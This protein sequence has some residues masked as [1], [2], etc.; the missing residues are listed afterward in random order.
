MKNIALL[1]T[2]IFGLLFLGG[3]GSWAGESVF[4]Y[5]TNSGENT[6]SA[7]DLVFGGDT[8]LSIIARPSAISGNVWGEYWV[9]LPDSNLLV[10]YGAM[11]WERKAIIKKRIRTNKRPEQILC[12]GRYYVTHP[13]NNSIS[14]I[15]TG[16][17]KIIKEIAVGLAP[18]GLALSNDGSL[19]A[20]VNM[21]SDDVTLIR[22]SDLHTIGTYKVGKTPKRAAFSVNDSLLFVSLYGENAVAVLDCRTGGVVK[23]I[24]VGRNPVGVLVTPGGHVLYVANQGTEVKPDNRVTKIKLPSFKLTTQLVCG[25]GCHGLAYD[26]YVESVVVTNFFDNTL[27]IISVQGEIE[28]RKV[29]KRPT[30]VTF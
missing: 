18:E 16:A 26:R 19:L 9:V 12:S 20:V 1:L 25:R 14:V 29:G 22:T 3:P 10:A 11:G 28:T 24:P 8:T 2:V 15:D 27:S 30:C 6:I 13:E 5:C 21:G 23:K 4:V 7:V 17:Q